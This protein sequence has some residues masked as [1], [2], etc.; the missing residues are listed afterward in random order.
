MKYMYSRVHINWNTHGLRACQLDRGKK[1]QRFADACVWL[2]QDIRLILALFNIS[3]ISFHCYEYYHSV[4]LSSTPAAN[5][6][7]DLAIVLCPFTTSRQIESP[8]KWG[9]GGEGRAMCRWSLVLKPL[10]NVW[11]CY[12]GRGGWGVF[13]VPQSSTTN[14]F[15]ALPTHPGIIQNFKQFKNFVLFGSHSLLISPGR[16]ISIPSSRVNFLA[17]S[18]SYKLPQVARQ[19]FGTFVTF[20]IW[21]NFLAPFD[22]PSNF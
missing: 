15:L 13:G 8:L 6:L 4:K 2:V 12:G 14:A 19:L 11:R 3:Y 17:S 16:Y 5:I 22:N 9:G 20:A 21:S 7:N 18:L 10:G 1:E